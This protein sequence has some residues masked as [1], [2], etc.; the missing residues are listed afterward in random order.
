MRVRFE[1]VE[2]NST[3]IL[4]NYYRVSYLYR[5]T[6]CTYVVDNREVYLRIIMY[7]VMFF[8]VFTSHLF[9]LS[10]S[11]VLTLPKKS[12]VLSFYS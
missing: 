5:R 1:G 3:I 10:I 2:R 4:A 12:Y 6:K 9:D 11:H 7:M 8:I